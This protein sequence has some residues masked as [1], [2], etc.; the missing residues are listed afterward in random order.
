MADV[1]NVYYAVA[2][3]MG[4]VAIIGAFAGAIGVV[5]KEYRSGL[6]EL[7]E[8]VDKIQRETVTVTAFTDAMEDLLDRQDERWKDYMKLLDERFKHQD[9]RHSDIKAALNK[10]AEGQDRVTSALADLPCPPPS[11]KG[12]C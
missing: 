6:K 12:I 11:A 7:H 9:E 10:L 2:T 4:V 1:Q 8:R 3:A 5:V